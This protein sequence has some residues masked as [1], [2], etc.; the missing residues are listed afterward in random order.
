MSIE[1]RVEEAAGRMAER[2]PMVYAVLGIGLCRALIGW[3]LGMTRGPVADLTF[4]PA[5]YLVGAG[6]VATFF[7]IAMVMRRLV[8]L[9]DSN[10][11]YLTPP[12]LA[13]PG[14]A[15]VYLSSVT[16]AA[17]PGLLAVGLVAVSGGYA[18]LLVLWLEQLATF[19]PRKMLWAYGLGYF[20][21]VGVWC[22]TTQTTPLLNALLAACSAAGSTYLLA[23]AWR[24][25]PKRDVATRPFKRDI[26]PPGL[27]VLVSILSLSF[28]IGDSIT[29]MGHSTVYSKMGMG[30]PELC[31]LLGLLLIPAR[32]DFSLFFKATVVLVAL[33]L[34]GI[35]FPGELL[36]FGQ[37]LMSAADESLQLF[38]LILACCV[39]RS[40]EVS[41]AGYTA[42]IMGCV[43]L[44]IRLGIFVGALLAGN[45]GLL[46]GV[47]L[48][49]VVLAAAFILRLGSVDGQMHLDL[50]AQ[51]S[52]ELLMDYARSKGLSKREATVFLLLMK[53]L[54]YG[55]IGE[56]LFIAPSTV[57]AHVS[58][59]F[60]KCGVHGRAELDQSV[61]RAVC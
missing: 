51:P 34:G 24:R 9:R 58:R 27:L 36:G 38:A 16:G 23:L 57:R 32:F 53:G 7:L 1:R 40:R 18:A 3:A 22:V 2:L 54:D 28:G 33:G 31:A 48:G 5:Q 8:L 20:V 13:V 29:G 6:E 26:V 49:M 15:C 4:I 55:E 17:A 47:S 11:A 25:A 60:E 14:A 46:Y 10:A 50:E 21:N 61:K 30:L 44:F 39:S 45:A 52:N 43:T 12:V 35:L 37:T 56:E 59:I 41:S 42:L 19:P